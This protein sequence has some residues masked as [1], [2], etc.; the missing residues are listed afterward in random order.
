[1]TVKTILDFQRSRLTF[2]TVTL[3]QNMDF[4]DT[5]TYRSIDF[6]PI[7]WYINDRDFIL[8]EADAH[9]CEFNAAGN[10]VSW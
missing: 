4:E 2:L 7:K 8:S 5:R 10:A 3:H 1:M 6:A 9:T